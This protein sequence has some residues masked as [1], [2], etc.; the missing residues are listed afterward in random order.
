MR[1]DF[2]E[3]VKLEIAH[4]V[5]HRCSHPECRA[6]TRGPQLDRTKALNVGVA[7]HIHA[8]SPDGPRY[9]PNMTP[10]Q[11]AGHENG[12]WLCQN[13]GKLVDNDEASFPADLL[14]EWKANAEEAAFAEIGKTAVATVSVQRK[15]IVEFPEP[16][17]PLGLMGRETR[18]WAVKVRFISQGARVAVLEIGLEEEGVGKWIIELVYAESGETVRFPIIVDPAA[19]VWVR[20]RS[21]VSYSEGG[22]RNVGPLTLLVRDDSQRPG[23]HHRVPTEGVEGGSDS[24]HEKTSREIL[25][26]LAALHRQHG[27]D[28]WMPVADLQQRV[29]AP[30]RVFNEVMRALTVG[31][32]NLTVEM[33][34]GNGELRVRLGPSGR[35][36]L[37]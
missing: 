16:V 29:D 22:F 36:Q 32:G 19:D 20:A 8:A 26:I 30:G 18:M 10:E 35:F 11:R 28:A 31:S 23:Q 17:N 12:I 7:A 27:S 9:D 2:R 14:R 1:D 37:G 15:L 34:R 3:S 21:P 5:G 24:G 33:E 6:A 4:R 25:E 13:H